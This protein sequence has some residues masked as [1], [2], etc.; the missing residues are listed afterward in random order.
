LFSGATA[1]DHGRRV[2][3]DD[4]GGACPQHLIGGT[5]DI[6][7]Q[8]DNLGL[9]TAGEKKENQAEQTTGCRAP[10]RNRMDGF[11]G[12]EQNALRLTDVD[13]SAASIGTRS[14]D[15]PPPMGNR[16]RAFSECSAP[17]F[18]RFVTGGPRRT[19]KQFIQREPNTCPLFRTSSRT[20]GQAEVA[21]T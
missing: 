3:P 15:S 4:V 11:H 2:L 6:Q 14:G 12:T 16:R 10:A 13:Q 19:Q 1:N 7:R 21:F 20:R 17:V 5:R 18:R 9:G 8:A